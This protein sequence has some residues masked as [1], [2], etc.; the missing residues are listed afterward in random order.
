MAQSALHNV[1]TAEASKAG[2]LRDTTTKLSE[3]EKELEEVKKSLDGKRALEEE[4]TKLRSDLEQA[5]ALSEQAYARGREE[6]RLPAI[7]EFLESP[8]LDALVRLRS[9]EINQAFYYKGIQHLLSA[10]RIQGALD[11]YLPY[12]DPYKNIFGKDYKA[13]SLPPKL[14]DLAD[15]EFAP[16][17]DEFGV[18]MPNPDVLEAQSE[19][20]DVD[21]E[22]DSRDQGEQGTPSSDSSKSA[23]DVQSN[24]GEESSSSSD[25]SD[26]SESGSSEKKEQERSDHGSGVKESSQ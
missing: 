24:D 6:G 11:N 23:A 10:G 20:E 18:P 13:S 17:L 21:I 4:V 26:S 12:L 7:R 2:Q 9:G 22:G 14:E 16:F 15:H 3:V 19:D 8:F 25:D 5:K 1:L